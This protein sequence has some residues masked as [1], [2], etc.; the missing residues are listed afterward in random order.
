MQSLIPRCWSTNP[1]DRPSFEDI[2]NE[3]R[4]CGFAILP[5]AD[6]DVIRKAVSE[7]LEAERSLK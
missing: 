7:V 6:A 5:G 3:F 4:S 2:L 1:N